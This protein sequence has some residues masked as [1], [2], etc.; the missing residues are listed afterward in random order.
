V[1]EE[2]HLLRS[3]VVDGRPICFGHGLLLRYSEAHGRG[4][5]WH[6]MLL[7]VPPHDALCANPALRQR[8]RVLA[9]TSDGKQL[10]GQARPLPF[11]SAPDCLRLIGT[12]PLVEAE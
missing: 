10:R 12:S 6:V 9:L 8:Y 2:M 4:E 3:V 7:R 5:H 1:R 11:R